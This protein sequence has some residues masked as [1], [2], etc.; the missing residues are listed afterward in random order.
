MNEGKLREDLER[1]SRAERLLND[2]FVKDA[3][4][5]VEAHIIGKFREA[6]IRDEEGVV[7]AKQLLHSLTLFRG[8]FEDAIRNG[9]LAANALDPKKRG[10]PFLGDMRL[11]K[12][13]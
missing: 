1:G 5:L 3:F 9:K 4:A 13:K 12:R 10:A 11:W 6:P 7:K 8:V 2:P